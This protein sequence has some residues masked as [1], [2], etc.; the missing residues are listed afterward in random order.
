M[1]PFTC[2]AYCT[3][4]SPFRKVYRHYRHELQKGEHDEAYYFPERVEAVSG[5]AYLRNFAHDGYARR[6]YDADEDYERY[7][8]A[9]AV[10]GDSFADEHYEHCARGVNDHEEHACKPGGSGIR[11]Q[12][13][14]AAAEHYGVDGAFFRGDVYDYAYRLC[15]CED[16][17]YVTGYLGYL[18]PAFLTLARKA[19]QRGNAH[20]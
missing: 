8:V 5:A 2:F 18:L 6:G 12:A 17:G 13:A 4:Y 10:F 1:R 15:Y 3:G 19:L 14:G 11:H 20:R 16:D 7:A 9:D